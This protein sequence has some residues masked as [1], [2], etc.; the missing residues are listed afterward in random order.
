MTSVLSLQRLAVA[1]V[2]VPVKSDISR[3]CENTISTTRCPYQT[4]TSYAC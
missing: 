2:G 4:S 1:P 3:L